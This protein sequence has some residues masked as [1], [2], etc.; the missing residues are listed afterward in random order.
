MKF[1][2]LKEDKILELIDDDLLRYMKT[3]LP[4]EC[5]TEN[6]MDELFD[7]NATIE[8]MH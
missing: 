5:L 4:I 8:W 6:A 1:L 2:S 7:F 3:K